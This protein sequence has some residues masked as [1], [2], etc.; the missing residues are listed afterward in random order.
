MNSK[1]RLITTAIHSVQKF[2]SIASAPRTDGLNSFQQGRN[3]SDRKLKWFSS[4]R[5]SA[6]AAPRYPFSRG[7]LSLCAKLKTAAQERRG[8]ARMALGDGLYG[9]NSGI[10]HARTRCNH[11]HL[12][13]E[14]LKLSLPAVLARGFSCG[15]L[16]TVSSSPRTDATRAQRFFKW[17]AY[18]RYKLP[19][20]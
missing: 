15:E 10:P 9:R 17:G 8:G 14:A 13:L 11:E 16:E 3:L 2:E 19:T 7:R 20:W 6:K 18:N 12:L 4:H 5:S 1:S